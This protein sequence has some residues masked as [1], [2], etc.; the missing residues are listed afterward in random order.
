MDRPLWK[1]LQG[2]S[3]LQVVKGQPAETVGLP[4]FHKQTFVGKDVLNKE[5]T[6]KEVDNVCPKRSPESL[7]SVTM[8]RQGQR[9]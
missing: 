9:N 5:L 8:M 7:Q 3:A 2:L 4:G 1:F 6:F